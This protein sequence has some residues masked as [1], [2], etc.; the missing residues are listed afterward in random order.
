MD[1]LKSRVI[2]VLQ[3]IF[4]YLFSKA[5]EL[6]QEARAET[7]EK[8]SWLVSPELEELVFTI[9][10]T[11]CL[12]HGLRFFPDEN[13]ES[14]ESEVNKFKKCQDTHTKKK[15]KITTQSRWKK[16]GKEMTFIQIKNFNYHPTV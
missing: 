4:V 5:V 1:P 9:Y 6:S 11:S 16:K 14:S 12:I 15:T 3:G 10:F 13:K 7:H 8:Q 2:W